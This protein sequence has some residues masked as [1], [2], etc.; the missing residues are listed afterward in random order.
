MQNYFELFQ[1]PTQF[2]LDPA[3]LDQAYREVQNRVHPDKFAQA[4]DAEKRV[5][6]QWATHANQAYQVLKKPLQRARYLCELHG[7][8]LQTESNTSM[9]AA[10]L[11]QQMEWRE[12]FDEARSERDVQALMKLEKEVQL[13]QK[14][15]LAGV[16]QMLERGEFESAAQQIR[17]CMFIE[18]FIADIAA[19]DE[20]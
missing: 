15:K 6:M 20:V 12:A 16:G 13:A 11:M 10:F 14:E 3:A 4:S 5:A 7:T 8:D 2:A 1:L 9:P 18:K 19:L 17:A